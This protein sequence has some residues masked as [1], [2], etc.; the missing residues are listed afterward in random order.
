M[1]T[2]QHYLVEINDKL[3]GVQKGVD[4]VLSRMDDDKLG[5]LAKVRK[6]R[7]LPRAHR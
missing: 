7:V 1:A 2:Q 3:E 4:E 6:S 5:T